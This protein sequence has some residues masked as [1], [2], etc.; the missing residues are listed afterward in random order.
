VAVCNR[1]QGKGTI[2]PF[3]ALDATRCPVCIGSGWAKTRRPPVVKPDRPDPRTKTFIT[4][5]DDDP[6]ALKRAIEALP[7]GIPEWEKHD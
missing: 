4:L 5:H 1:C 3:K 6:D 2:Q 7:W